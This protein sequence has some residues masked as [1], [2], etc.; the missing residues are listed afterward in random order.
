MNTMKK[1]TAASVLALALGGSAMAKTVVAVSMPGIQVA[2]ENGG[3]SGKQKLQ[4][5]KSSET[6]QQAPKIERRSERSGDNC[7]AQKGGTGR[8]D[9]DGW[10]DRSKE[11]PRR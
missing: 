11:L 3:D 10:N 5:R 6:L 9:K 1:I 8:S 7:Q 2:Y 4:E